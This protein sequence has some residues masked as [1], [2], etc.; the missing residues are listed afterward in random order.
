[1]HH[2]RLREQDN[3]RYLNALKAWTVPPEHDAL[4]QREGGTGV[5]REGLYGCSEMMT[6][7]LL[8]LIDDG[9]IRRPV[10]DWAP[11]Q[12]LAW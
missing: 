10:Y 4:I 1:M 2:L 9:I 6:H 5:F 8:T 3:P 11:L 12:R 7:G